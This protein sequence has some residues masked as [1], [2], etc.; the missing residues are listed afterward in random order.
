MEKNLLDEQERFFEFIKNYEYINEQGRF[1]LEAFCVYLSMCFSCDGILEHSPQPRDIYDL[2]I[3]ILESHANKGEMTLWVQTQRLIDWTPEVAWLYPDRHRTYIHLAGLVHAMPHWIYNIGHTLMN[4]PEPETPGK[5]FEWVDE[6]WVFVYSFINGF[7]NFYSEFL[8]EFDKK[9]TAKNGLSLFEALHKS[10]NDNVDFDQAIEQIKKRNFAQSDALEK[11]NKAIEAGFYLEAITLQECLIS[12]CLYNYLWAKNKKF[13]NP[14]F[15]K[16]ILEFNKHTKTHK[17]MID[18]I[19]S[20]RVKR[21]KA[22]HGYIESKI[23]A[24]SES[25]DNFLIFSKATA[26]E[27]QTLSQ[28]ICYWYTNE[29][30]NFMETRFDKKRKNYN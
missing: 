20:W 22:L 29:S 28:N 2:L 25:Q 4:L 12:N 30:V 1:D 13:K 16:L 24:L 3:E 7:H 18:E 27:G 10:I 19:D 8:K 26:I 17:K 23:E 6:E 21:N 15:Q 5:Y 11:I 14:S 9:T